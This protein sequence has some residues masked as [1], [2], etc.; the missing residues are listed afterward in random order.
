MQGEHGIQQH[1]NKVIIVQIDNIKLI[2]THVIN[3]KIGNINID[4]IPPTTH[5]KHIKLQANN[6][7]GAVHA[8][9]K[10]LIIQQ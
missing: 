1:A 10:Q 3:N 9:T 2:K 8:I 7:T 4:I 5:I 6:H